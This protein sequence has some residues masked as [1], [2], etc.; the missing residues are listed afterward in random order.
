MSAVLADLHTKGLL[1]Q[2]VVVLATE[3][4]RTPRINDNDGRDQQN[5]ALRCLLAGA[6]IREGKADGNTHS[7]NFEAFHHFPTPMS[8]NPKTIMVT[9]R[10]GG[11]GV[12]PGDRRN[13]L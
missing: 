4:G 2:T 6:G 11:Y 10:P 5:D 8:D 13:R 12:R 3:F 7:D 1:D 9:E